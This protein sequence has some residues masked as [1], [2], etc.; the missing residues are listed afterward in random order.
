[1][2]RKFNHGKRFQSKKNCDN[3]T[4]YGN[5]YIQ[6]MALNHGEMEETILI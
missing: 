5:V 3:W 6:N 2:P 1:M 4:S